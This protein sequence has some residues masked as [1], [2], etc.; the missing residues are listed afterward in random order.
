MIDL[1]KVIKGLE[2]HGQT[3]HMCVKE[4]EIC[5]YFSCEDCFQRLM[6]DALE[7]LK[8]QQPRLMELEELT[9]SNRRPVWI[10]VMEDDGTGA[11]CTCAIWKNE[12]IVNEFLITIY[13]SADSYFQKD[14]YGKFWRC[15]TACPSEAQMEAVKWE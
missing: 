2:I 7:L 12:M 4:G 1:E 10:E 8:A 3:H 11:W 5:P 15:W 6:D 14:D 9:R 13:G